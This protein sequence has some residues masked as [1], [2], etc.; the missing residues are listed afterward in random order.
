[1]A[2][3]VKH[4]CCKSLCANLS[5]CSSE[6]QCP[7]PVIPHGTEISPRR[8]EYT[9]G[10]QAEFQCDHGYVLKG[11]ERVQC[12]SDG[13]W[14]PPVPH[15]ARGE[16]ESHPWGG[17]AGRKSWQESGEGAQGTALKGFSISI[18]CQNRD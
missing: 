2:G 13:M 5:C 3:S 14:R 16:W 9:F 11:S 15:C 17:T 10:Q 7:R 4:R 12:S 1:M 8:A 18:F 6:V